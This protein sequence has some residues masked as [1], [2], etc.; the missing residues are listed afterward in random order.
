MLRSTFIEPLTEFSTPNYK[1]LQPIQFI[2]FLKCFQITGEPTCYVT[3]I[4]ESINWIA[5]DC[6]LINIVEDQTSLKF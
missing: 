4:N 3:E 1:K 6:R 5:G 2:L